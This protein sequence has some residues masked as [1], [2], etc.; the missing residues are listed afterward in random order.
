MR[1]GQHW[2]SHHELFSAWLLLSKYRGNELG[3]L[4]LRQKLA[5]I[6]EEFRQAAENMKVL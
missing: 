3:I 5:E 1:N 2:F 6:I 4:F